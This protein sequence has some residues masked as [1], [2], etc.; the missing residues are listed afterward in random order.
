V[1]DACSGRSHRDGH[2]QEGCGNRGGIL[3]WALVL[4]V[5]QCLQNAHPIV[6]GKHVVEIARYHADL[7]AMMCVVLKH[8]GEHVNHAANLLISEDSPMYS[9]V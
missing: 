2:A 6:A 4:A 8:V 3:A 1:P 9:S 5:E 7:T